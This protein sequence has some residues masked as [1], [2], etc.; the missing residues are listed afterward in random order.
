MY[1]FITESENLINPINFLEF[2][3]YQGESMRWWAKKNE[4]SSSRFIGFDSFQGLPEDWNDR[5]PQTSF[6]T[7]GDVPQIKDERCSFQVGWF[8][9]TLPKFVANFAFDK[10]TIIHLDADLYSST[11]FVLITIAPKLKAGDILI[12]DE[13]YDWMHEFRAFLDFISCFQME[14]EVIAAVEDF[15]KVT[16]KIK[17]TP[18]FECHGNYSVLNR[19]QK[20]RAYARST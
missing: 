11:L 20:A 16:L 13:F 2:G 12:F 10:P 5:K 3:V 17:R 18:S 1:E 8:Q 6:S 14:Y 15:R 19:T 4:H 9:D 7:N